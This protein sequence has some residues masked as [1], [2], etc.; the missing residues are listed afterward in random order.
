MATAVVL[1]ITAVV[2]TAGVAWPSLEDALRRQPG[3]LADGEAWRAVT[4]LLVH[5]EGWLQVVVDLVGIAVVGRATEWALGARQFLAVYLLTGVVGH[6]AG[7]AWDPTSAGSSVAV[8]G[9]AGALVAWQACTRHR[10]D[11]AG[12]A[13][14]VYAVAV[15]A[16]LVG[17]HAS[18]TVGGALAAVAAGVTVQALGRLPAATAPEPARP[19][20]PARP[21]EPARP[22][23]PAR[24]AEPAGASGSGGDGCRNDSER[25]QNGARPTATVA[26]TT[27]VAVVVTV[28]G[29]LLA[30]VRDLHGPAILA[31]VAAGVVLA[32]RP[33]FRTGSSSTGPAA[34]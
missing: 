31:G 20:D 9:T 27:A 26:V 25:R 33:A 17:G 30:A 18:P 6:L 32:G 14:S 23:D 15:I 10:P 24:P 21:A 11:P 4:P 7:A 34:C 12:V 5:P 16:A 29:T 19:A 2:T 13:A 1:A 8:L 28:L 3:A 22:A